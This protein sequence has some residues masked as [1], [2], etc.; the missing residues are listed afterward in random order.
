VTTLWTIISSARFKA[1]VLFVAALVVVASF[2]GA[3]YFFRPADNQPDVN[4]VD[5]A[6]RKE[7]RDFASVVRTGMYIKNFETFDIRGDSFVMGAVIWFDFLTSEVTLN[8]VRNFS[9][10]NGKILEK[11]DGDVQINGSRM[12]VR[13][14]I[15]VDFKSQLNYYRYPFDDHRV[16]LVMTNNSVTPSEMYFTVVN[17]SFTLAPD[18]YTANWQVLGLDTA[19][20]YSKLNLDPNDASKKMLRPVVAYSINFAKSSLRNVLIIFIPLSISMLFGLLTFFLG[21]FDVRGRATMIAS[22]LTANLSYRFIID[23]MMPRAIGYLTTT[24]SLYMLY[25]LILILIFIFQTWLSTYTVNKELQPAKASSL[26]RT[27]DLLYLGC[28]LI[29]VMYIMYVL[30]W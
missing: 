1:A 24:D 8:T 4:L 25:L 15:R 11:S 30:L 6:M 10:I 26:Q 16:S 2:A 29:F 3:M 14:D 9:F 19:W 21:L 13:F 5:M 23:N 20:G 18:A 28:V 7:I 27:N 22:A 17:N 12:L